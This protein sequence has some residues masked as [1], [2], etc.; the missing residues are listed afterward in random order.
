VPFI[1]E[2]STTTIM[3]VS[4]RVWH[5]ISA[6]YYLTGGPFWIHYWGSQHFSPS[7]SCCWVLPRPSSGWHHPRSRNRNN[8]SKHS[9]ATSCFNNGSSFRAILIISFSISWTI[10]HLS[11]VFRIW[12]ITLVPL[13]YLSRFYF[14]Q[15]RKI[16]LGRYLNCSSILSRYQ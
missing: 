11:Y 3:S 13:W 1:D 2:S 7:S 16:Y 9:N 10:L 12:F 6:D 8:L 5:R 15:S 4:L 14:L